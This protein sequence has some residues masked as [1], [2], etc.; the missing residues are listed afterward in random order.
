MPTQWQDQYTD[1]SN[2]NNGNELQNG[3]DILAQ[4]VNVA[5][6]NSAFIKRRYDEVHLYRHIFE[7]YGE[8]TISGTTWTY[9]FYYTLYTNTDTPITKNNIHDYF[10][11]AYNYLN[12]NVS[13][14]MIKNSTTYYAVVSVGIRKNNPDILIYRIDNN[15]YLSSISV[16]DG[17][18]GVRDNI[19]MIF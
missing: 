14:M 13:G 7:F 6:E 12:L 10:D 17:T 18:N 11:N 1:L 8:K 2:V 9:G 5:L 16:E 3:D 19:E 15:G 4:H